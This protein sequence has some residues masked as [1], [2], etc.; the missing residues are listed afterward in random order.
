MALYKID[1][2][3]TFVFDLRCLERVRFLL[4]IGYACAVLDKPSSGLVGILA[5]SRCPKGCKACR[6][7]YQPTDRQ[8][9]RR[10]R[11][12]RRL[13][14]IAPMAEAG[15]GARPVRSGPVLRRTTIDQAPT[16]RRPGVSRR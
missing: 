3:F 11:R 2:Y 14:P 4:T 7:S 6:R 1:I 15:G 9:Y 16:W 10:R 13:A 5:A 12:R 8:F